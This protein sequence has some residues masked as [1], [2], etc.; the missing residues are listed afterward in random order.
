ML[1]M[2]PG[3]KLT[4]P[5]PRPQFDGCFL[6]P[7]SPPLN[8]PDRPDGTAY[9][10]GPTDDSDLPARAADVTVSPSAVAALVAQTAHLAPDYLDSTRPASEGGAR[11]ER[12]QACY[13]PVGSGDPVLGRIEGTEPGKGVYVAAGHSCWGIVRSLPFLSPFTARQARDS[14]SPPSAR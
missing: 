3:I 14:H 1:K 6:V 7:C 13:L 9:A 8:Y 11:V 4:T 10:C 2:R 5:P 12:E